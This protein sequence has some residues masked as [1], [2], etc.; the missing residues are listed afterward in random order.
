MLRRSGQLRRGVALLSTPGADLQKCLRAAEQD[1]PD[2]TRQ[3]ARSHETKLDPRRRAFGPDARPR[4]AVLTYSGSA[5]LVPSR[6]DIAVVN[7]LRSR[8]LGPS[9]PRFNIASLEPRGGR[10]PGQ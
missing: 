4:R 2:A 6:R 7:N 3:R 10:R 8:A 1:G 5:V 9:A